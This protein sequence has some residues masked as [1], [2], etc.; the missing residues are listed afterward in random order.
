MQ[1]FERPTANL[2][3]IDDEPQMLSEVASAMDR[4]GYACRC[5]QT[6]AEALRQ[7]TLSAPDL[8]VSDI[9]LGDVS[10]LDLCEEI[11]ALPGLG[12]TPVI[13][14][15]GAQIPNIVSKAHAAGGSYYLRKP[16]DPEVLVELVDKALWMPSLALDR[17][18]L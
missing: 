15:S 8:I 16:F 9:N 10:G 7:A 14:L 4:A 3:V 5:C 6:P 12:D 17:A 13:F 1:A 18:R 11:K 2:I